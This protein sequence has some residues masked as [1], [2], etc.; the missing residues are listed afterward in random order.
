MVREFTLA[1]MLFGVVAGCDK[2]KADPTGPDDSEPQDPGPTVVTPVAGRFPIDGVVDLAAVGGVRSTQVEMRGDFGQGAASGSVT[3][4]WVAVNDDRHLYLAFRWSDATSD[5]EFDATGPIQ[6]DGIVVHFDD[7]GNGRQEVGEDGKALLAALSGSQY[8][9]MHTTAAANPTDVVGDGLGRMARVA[10]GWAAEFLI[11]IGDDASGED[12]LKTAAT[13]VNFLIYDAVRLQEGAGAVGFA[14]GSVGVGTNS[15]GWPALPWADAVGSGHPEL[16]TGLGGLI[17][18]V[19]D[20]GGP[21]DIYSFDP[22]SRQVRQITSGTGLF[23]DGVSLSHDRTRVAFHGAPSETAY[24]DYEIYSIR[25]DGSGL[26]RLTDNHI[27][28]GHPAWSPDDERIV[29]ASYRP[30]GDSR[31]VLM[32][33]GGMEL[34]VLTPDGVADNDPDFL[35]DGRIVFK[36]DRFSAQP[37]VR[38]AVMDADGGGVL[39]ISGA[40]GTSDHDATS[41]G[42]VAIFERFMRGTNY[43]TDPESGFTPWNLIEAR[44]DGSGERTLLANGWIN[45]LPVFDPSG[46]YIAHLRGVGYT[47]VQIMLPDGTELGRLIPGM[48]RV[49]YMD[50]K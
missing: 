28:D 48:T 20:H 42:T 13:R 10:G 14:F 16:P 15:G 4:D 50:W 11:P 43:A 1:V 47:D 40:A 37:E 7:D 29:Y 35:P 25:V 32:T 45:W 22:A 24:N 8:V 44:V 46:T 12:G 30:G 49:S 21:R 9:D 34:D 33:P 23:I 18:F 36:T 38:M 3:V 39:Q 19:S 5:A 27:L 31:L 41:N 2:S 17:V 6:N 26:T